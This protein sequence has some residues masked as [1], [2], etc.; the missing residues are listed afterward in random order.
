MVTV[1]VT[2]CGPISRPEAAEYYISTLGSDHNSG[3]WDNPFQTIPR[4]SELAKPGDI[5]HVLPGIYEGGFV[6]RSNG[7]AL[8]RIIYA[9]T[10]KWQAKIVP[11]RISSSATGWENQGDYVDIL[12]FQIDG[13]NNSG[14]QAWAV[15]VE[16]ASSNSRVVGN[17]IHHIKAPC[18]HN[19][20][21]GINAY[22]WKDNL[23]SS[24]IGNF[25]HDIGDT[26]EGCPWVHGIYH[27]H[28]GLIVNNVVFRAAGWG[29]HLWHKPHDVTIS[30]NTVFNNKSGGIII[31]GEP[32]EIS[33]HPGNIIVANNIVYDN[34]IGIGEEGLTSPNNQYIANLIYG[35]RVDWMLQNNIF[36]SRSV[37]A[38]PRFVHYD[39]DGGGDY[40]LS[41]NSPAID[42]GIFR[43]AAATDILGIT[44]PQGLGVDIGAYEFCC[45]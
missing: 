42:A 32:S 22:Q 21:A 37:T 18:D 40:R 19:G 11:P 45:R 24:I 9:S 43:Y 7:T 25:V 39:P 34:P 28:S 2:T 23:N 44:R 16:D 15:G 12:D 20:G 10:V 35:N 17:W 31:G 41:D 14:G 3:S 30:N 38:N 36:P 8:N 27:Q 26:A 13:S 6:T 33:A 29:I 1:L 4:A 5:V